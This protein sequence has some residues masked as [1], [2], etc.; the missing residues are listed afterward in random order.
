[1]RSSLRSKAP[2][3]TFPDVE[4]NFR[5][6]FYAA[7]AL[8]WGASILN[9]T[10]KAL[11]VAVWSGRLE[12]GTL[13]RT[14]YT[15]F[16]PLDYP[17]AVL[18]AFFF[19]GTNGHHEAYSLFL[20]D[21]YIN[22]QLGYL[23]VYAE[24]A[25]PGQKP[26]WI[27]SPV[28]FALLWQACGGAVA[29][30]L[31][32]GLHVRWASQERLA[33]VVDLHKARALPIAFIL[34]AFAPM[35]A[36]M[37]P[38]WLGPEGRSAASQQMIIALFQPSP[39]LFSILL[40]LFTRGSAYLSH[41]GRLGP[42]G[43]RDNKK[44]RRWVQGSYLAAAAASIIGRVYVLIRVLTAEDS[45]SVSLLRMYVPFPFTGPA[46]TN[47]VLVG[48]PWL[49]LQWDSIIISLA[50]SFWALVLLK[51]DRIVRESTGIVALVL[52]AG[53]VVLGPGATVTMAL[54]IREGHL[55]ERTGN[56]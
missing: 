46:G 26:S 31:Y 39:I 51:Q 16:P 49:F 9:G 30:P 12:D 45:G 13:L 32:F 35:T 14:D 37:A 36:L 42:D 48:G 27:Q 34:G 29:F 50:S 44:A 22:L 10:I 43:P 38:T 24:A 5:I 8:L 20:F 55:P 4:R 33:Q 52:T 6:L 40:A 56:P 17:L 53:A 11:L 28:Y 23:W 3:P 54:C 21:L 15:G 47:E 2:A 7:V 41:G 1:M 19:S 25:R 18:V